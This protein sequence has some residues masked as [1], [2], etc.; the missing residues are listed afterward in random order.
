MDTNEEFERDFIG[1]NG[2]IKFKI[3][4][5]GVERCFELLKEHNEWPSDIEKYQGRETEMLIKAIGNLLNRRNNREV[6]I[7]T[8]DTVLLVMT[9]VWFEH[10]LEDNAAASN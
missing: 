3:E 10:L 2:E 1:P 8:T 7:D 6:K 4:K 5:L 9:A